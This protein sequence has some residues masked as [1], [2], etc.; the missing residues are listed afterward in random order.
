MERRWGGLVGRDSHEAVPPAYVLA[1]HSL[2]AWMGTQVR[3]PRQPEPAHHAGL[4]ERLRAFGKVPLDPLAEGCDGLA[5][6]Q[7]S[8]SRIRIITGSIS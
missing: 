5:N 4:A 7:K 3:Y 8:L 6:A 1:V 2:C